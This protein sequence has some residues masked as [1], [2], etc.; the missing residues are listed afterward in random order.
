MKLYYGGFGRYQYYTV[1]KDH[2][3]AIQNIQNTYNLQALP[4]TVQEINEVDG[5]EIVAKPKPK[6]KG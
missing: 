1:A 4:V 2:A 5:Y 6:A 3:E